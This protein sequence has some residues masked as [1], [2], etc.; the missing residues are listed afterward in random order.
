[1]RATFLQ[2]GE[3]LPEI[4]ALIDELS[5]AARRRCN[6]LDDLDDHVQFARKL[7]I[8]QL[9]IARKIIAPD[10]GTRRTTASPGVS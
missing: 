3:R 2:I 6:A 4:E 8:E 7:A 9:L 10:S 1:L 5:L